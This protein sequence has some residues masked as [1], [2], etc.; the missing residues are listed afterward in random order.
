MLFENGHK[1]KRMETDAI[2]VCLRSKLVAQKVTKSAR[3]VHN[4]R[5]TVVI[6]TK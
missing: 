1:Q 4:F 2:G 3:K 6:M 5:V